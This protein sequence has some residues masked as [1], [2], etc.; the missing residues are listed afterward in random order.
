MKTLRHILFVTI[1]T[2]GMIF[3]AGDFAGISCLNVDIAQAAG[4]EEEEN[5]G[6]PRLFIDWN[7]SVQEFQAGEVKNLVIPIYNDGDGVASEC[8][9]TLSVSNPNE[10]PFQLDGLKTTRSLTNINSKQTIW[11]DFGPVSVSSA[12]K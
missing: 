6:T 1:L 7:N 4:D 5:P 11:A 3:P 10:F 2:M 8:Y 12:A 9:A